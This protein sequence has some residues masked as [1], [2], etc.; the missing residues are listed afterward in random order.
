MSPE[1]TL[2][3]V[4]TKP[5][6]ENDRVKVWEMELEPGE[7]SDV[8]EHRLDYVLIQLEGD[9]IAGIFEP[10]TGGSYPPGT[11]EGDVAPGS[12]IYIERGGIEA[13][14][15]TGQR[16]YREILVELKD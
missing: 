15:N 5:L 10:D 16:R 1:R 4:A 13:A 7:S 3:D 11:V 14:K 8:H 6:F 9:K 2:G 12:V